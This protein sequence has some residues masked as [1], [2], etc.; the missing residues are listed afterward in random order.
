MISTTRQI[1]LAF[2]QGLNLIR[3]PG[4]RMFVI[5]PFLFNLVIFGLLS[6]LAIEQFGIFL[7]WILGQLP[8]WLVAIAKWLLS[9]MFGVLLLITMGYTFTLIANLLASP[10][11]GLLAEKV[12]QKLTGKTLPEESITAMIIR[13]MGRELRKWAYLIPRTLGV[14]LICAILFFIPPL[15]LA[16]PF[17]GFFWVAWCMSI[18]YMDYPMDNHQVSFD[19]LKQTISDNKVLA[20]GFGSCVL[21]ASSIPIVNFIVMPVAVTTATVLWVERLQEQHEKQQGKV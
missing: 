6:W 9:L 18:E 2:R 15:N 3:E 21:M 10:F 8:D 17:I 11:N 12:E 14:F 5:I 19:S 7:D 4:L 13:S 20:L 16:V 1:L